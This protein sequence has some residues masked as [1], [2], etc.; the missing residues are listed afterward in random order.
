MKDSR[1]GVDFQYSMI[2]GAP[3]AAAISRALRYAST[4]SL[5]SSTGK[6]IA[7][8]IGSPTMSALRRSVRDI[9]RLNSFW[10]RFL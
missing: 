8:N 1:Y 6:S 4:S 7:A 5:S 2:P 9:T 3:A 10:I